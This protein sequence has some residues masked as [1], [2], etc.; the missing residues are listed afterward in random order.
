MCV[1]NG[2]Y[3]SCTCLE[4]KRSVRIVYAASTLQDGLW[5]KWDGTGILGYKQNRLVKAFTRIGRGR[6]GVGRYKKSA[7]RLRESL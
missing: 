1:S 4:G 3:H 5:E 2:I 6:N 7:N